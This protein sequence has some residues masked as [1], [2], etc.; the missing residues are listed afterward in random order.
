VLVHGTPMTQDKCDTG[1]TPEENYKQTQ[2]PEKYLEDVASGEKHA[3]VLVYETPPYVQADQARSS[4][5]DI[6]DYSR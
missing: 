1:L 2:Y 3:F 5:D 6:A 4:V